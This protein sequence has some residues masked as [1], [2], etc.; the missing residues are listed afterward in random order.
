M[1]FPFLYSWW[2]D[3]SLD[4]VDDVP[5]EDVQLDNNVE[6]EDVCWFLVQILLGYIFLVGLLRILYLFRNMIRKNHGH[7]SWNRLKCSKDPVSGFNLFVGKEKAGPKAPSS[8]PSVRKRL[9]KDQPKTTQRAFRDQ[10]S[11]DLGTFNSKGSSRQRS[12]TDEG[13]RTDDSVS[14]CSHER[15]EAKQGYWFRKPCC[16]RCKAKRTREWLAQHFFDQEPEALWETGHSE[17][18]VPLTSFSLPE[19]GELDPFMDRFHSCQ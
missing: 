11:S 13:S 12:Q 1:A 9:K 2:H 8:S 15:R 7:L 16:P 3:S 18:T 4:C 19:H 6:E 17:A 14:V 5:E 10:N